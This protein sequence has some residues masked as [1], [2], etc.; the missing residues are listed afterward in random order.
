MW[1]FSA[2]MWLERGPRMCRG[3]QIPRFPDLCTSVS[4][5][6][7]L[8]KC[9][10]KKGKA[11]DCLVTR[12]RL[13][14]MYAH[15][16]DVNLSSSSSCA[17]NWCCQAKLWGAGMVFLV[18][19]F[20]SLGQTLRKIN[21]VVNLWPFWKDRA[22]FRAPNCP[23]VGWEALCGGRTNYVGFFRVWELLFS[24]VSEEEAE[25]W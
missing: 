25:R 7:I 3:K 12:S 24:W 6:F 11:E 5:S 17:P 10:P 21:K 9:G 23:A 16:W 20:S 8:P 15:L 19:L 14:L 13:I 18:G 2:Q 4:E 1:Q 22:T